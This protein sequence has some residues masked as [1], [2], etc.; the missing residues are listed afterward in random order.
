MAIVSKTVLIFDF[1]SYS[2]PE[3]LRRQSAGRCFDVRCETLGGLLEAAMLAWH[4]LHASSPKKSFLSA[5]PF[6]GHHPGAFKVI[7]CGE[8]HSRLRL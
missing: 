7:R 6:V 3:K 4:C 5:S 1:L 2:L 8:A